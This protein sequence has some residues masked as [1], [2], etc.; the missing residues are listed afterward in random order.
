MNN[1]FRF[2]L[3][4]ATT[5]PAAAKFDSDFSAQGKR[6]TLESTRRQHSAFKLRHKEK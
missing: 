4:K 6:V 2:Y 1:T 5:I 3:L